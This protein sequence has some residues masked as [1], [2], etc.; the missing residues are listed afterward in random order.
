LQ[1]NRVH[2]GA[3]GSGGENATEIRG[4]DAKKWAPN[5]APKIEKDASHG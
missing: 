4:T 3:D 5:W 2:H 1:A